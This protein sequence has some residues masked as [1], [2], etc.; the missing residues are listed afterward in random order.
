MA[1]RKFSKKG[2]PKPKV[3]RDDLKVDAMK[4]DTTAPDDESALGPIMG[5]LGNDPTGKNSLASAL[6][7]TGD[8]MG[9]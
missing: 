3:E 6:Y 8:N 4:S 7:G 5:G 1:K 2:R 9:E